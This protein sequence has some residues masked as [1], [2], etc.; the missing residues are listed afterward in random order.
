MS[1]TQLQAGDVPLSTTDCAAV[2]YTYYRIVIFIAPVLKN[3]FKSGPPEFFS[4][5]SFCCLFAFI[6]FFA[7]PSPT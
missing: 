5:E 4:S 7:L 1:P 6:Q 3:I 2:L